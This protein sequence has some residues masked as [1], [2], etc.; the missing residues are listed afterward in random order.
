MRILQVITGLSPAGAERVV[1]E[2]SKGLRARG[3]EVLVVSL[4]PPPVEAA[5]VEE[6]RSAGG[7]S[8]SSAF[9]LDLG[10]S[11]KFAKIMRVYPL[12]Q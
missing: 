3:H 2:L 12:I 7:E 1:C 8:A 6:L 4:M 9:P 5:I 11:L 10:L